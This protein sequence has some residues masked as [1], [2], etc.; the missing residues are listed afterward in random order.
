MNK[1]EICNIALARIGVA[2]IESMGEASE[3]ARVCS[4]YYDFVRRNVLRK[5]PWTF[6]TRRVTL[7]Q[8][9]TQPPDYKFAYRYPTDAVALRKMYNK[10]YCGLPEK[11]EYKII[12]DA[13]GRVIFTDVEAANI[14]YT[15]DVQDVTLFDDEFIEALGWKLAAEIAFALTGNMNIAQTCVQAYNAYFAEAAADNAQEENVPDAKLHRLAAARFTGVE[16]WDTY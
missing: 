11:N 9:N 10:T 7:A 8:I 6:A 5:Y 1:I 15:A 4:Q 3:A 12:S 13:G 14:E 16:A 2:P